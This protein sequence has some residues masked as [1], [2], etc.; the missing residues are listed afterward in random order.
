MELTNKEINDK[1]STA[2]NDLREENLRLRLKITDLISR[3][4]KLEG[5]G[6]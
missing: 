3:V 6:E 5:K 1:F 2:C 4:R